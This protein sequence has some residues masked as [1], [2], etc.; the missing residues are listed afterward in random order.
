[1]R[2]ARVDDDARNAAR[3]R[4]GRATRD[5]ASIATRRRRRARE[6]VVDARRGDGRVERRNSVRCYGRAGARASQGRRS[7][8]NRSR[9]SDA[10]RRIATHRDARRTVNERDG[11]RNEREDAARG[12]VRDSGE[13]SGDDWNADGASSRADGGRRARAKT[14]LERLTTERRCV[15]A[16][17]HR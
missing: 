8:E 16:R 10:S 5:A 1:M 13:S 14:R 6:A 11:G 9:R 3:A 12:G 15:V 17:R 2:R 4:D 7:A